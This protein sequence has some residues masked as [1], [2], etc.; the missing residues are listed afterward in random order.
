MHS[1]NLLPPNLDFGCPV[2]AQACSS[3]TIHS[4]NNWSRNIM[5]QLSIL[6]ASSDPS[7]NKFQ[8]C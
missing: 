6:K 5:K 7:Q 2:T 3:K 8:F 1:S 4:L